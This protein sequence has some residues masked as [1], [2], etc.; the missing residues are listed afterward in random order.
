MHTV[1]PYLVVDGAQ[2]LIDFLRQAFGAV[3]VHSSLKS[4]GRIMHAQVR[5]GDS[6]VM[7]S[8]ATPECRL[9]PA[10]LH[11]YVPDVGIA[12]ANCSTSPRT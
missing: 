9:G 3:E 5:I 7:I 4:D 8:D 11:L 2:Q 1:T 6:V 10:M 12:T